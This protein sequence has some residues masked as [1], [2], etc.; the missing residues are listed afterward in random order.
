LPLEDLVPA[1]LIDRITEIEA[2]LGLDTPT[3]P[4]EQT[5]AELPYQADRAGKVAD[6][7]RCQFE[8][9]GAVNVRRITGADCPFTASIQVEDGDYWSRFVVVDG[10]ATVD[11]GDSPPTIRIGAEVAIALLDGTV[12][13]SL[14]ARRGLIPIENADGTA[15]EGPSGFAMMRTV[16][17]IL[18]GSGFNPEVM[19]LLTLPSTSRAEGLRP[20]AQEL[21][22]S[23]VPSKT[24]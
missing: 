11:E 1:S 2:Q 10:E 21:P 17:R 12:A 7:I 24:P 19:E 20:L 3:L 5:S 13:P 6:L 4:G 16:L 8:Q 14:V 18:S 9:F 22:L 23:L 15:V